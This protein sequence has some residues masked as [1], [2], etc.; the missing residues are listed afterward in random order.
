MAKLYGIKSELTKDARIQEL[1]AV[2]FAKANELEIIYYC[3]NSSI[4]DARDRHFIYFINPKFK[5]GASSEIEDAEYD[6]LYDEI[7][8]TYRTIVDWNGTPYTLKLCG[9]RYNARKDELTYLV[10]DAD[11]NMPMW[12]SGNDFNTENDWY[13]A[14]AAVLHTMK[15]GEDAE[16]HSE[17][18]EEE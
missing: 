4:K 5:D 15:D 10:M 9:V 14:T 2:G 8:S 3:L 7:E 17:E 13:L 11:G 6:A 1:N 12:V 18:E 16:Y